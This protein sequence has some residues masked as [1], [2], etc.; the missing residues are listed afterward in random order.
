[1]IHEAAIPQGTLRKF[2]Q[3]L[4]LL[5]NI[6]PPPSCG[7]IV[8]CS[9]SSHL[10]RNSPPLHLSSLLKWTYPLGLLSASQILAAPQL[11]KDAF[12]AAF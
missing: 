3:L 9:P 4:G 10:A 11:T 8:A 7:G 6:T 1:M 2:L 5:L 12:E